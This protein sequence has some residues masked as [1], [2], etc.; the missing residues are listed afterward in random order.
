MLFF[1]A[2]QSKWRNFETFSTQKEPKMSPPPPPSDSSVLNAEAKLFVPGVVM[3]TPP[4]KEKKKKVGKV[5]EKG[6][7]EISPLNWELNAR[8]E[9]LQSP[10]TT[11]PVSTIS[12]SAGGEKEATRGGGATT[13]AIAF[14]PATVKERKDDPFDKEIYLQK[15]VT[16]VKEEFTKAASLL[17]EKEETTT[18][19]T[20][21]MA[22]HVEVVPAASSED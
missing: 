14:T 10:F 22:L 5:E 2:R 12:T 3:V 6:G 8:N 1:L 4:P 19:R 18:T 13:K 17:H 9:R 15:A 16:L 21:E 20:T 7:E 11:P